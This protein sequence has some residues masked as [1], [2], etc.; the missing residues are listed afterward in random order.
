MQKKITN[1]IKKYGWFIGAIF[2]IFYVSLIN[3][4]PKGYTFPGGNVVQ[5]FSFPKILKDFS[6]T[7][8]NLLGEGFSLQYFSYNLYYVPF[9]LL[10]SV[11]HLSPSAQSFLYYYIFLM[12]S[13]WSFYAGL[14][15]YGKEGDKVDKKY[16]V[17]FSL[18]YTFNAYTFYNFYY[19]WGY[20]PLLFLYLLLPVIFGATYR[21]FCDSNIKDYRSLFILGVFFFLSNVANGNMPFFIALNIFLGRSL[22]TAYSLL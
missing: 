11:F 6:Y 18:I 3:I 7:W 8:S 9:Y 5:F 4:F 2:L 1:F 10:S 22:K 15:F 14:D 12:I 21:F 20:S 17:I 16:K 13:F 19:T